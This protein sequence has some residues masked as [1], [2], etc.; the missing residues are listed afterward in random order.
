MTQPA[1][2]RHTARLCFCGCELLEIHC[3]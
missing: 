3:E 1:V 2:I